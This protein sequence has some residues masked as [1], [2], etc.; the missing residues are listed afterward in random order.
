VLGHIGYAVVPWKRGRGYGKRA[1]ALLLAE[2]GGIGLP[3][4]DLT[5]D[6]ENLAS[7]AVILA[8]GGLLVERFRKPPAYGGQEALR[9]RIELRS[10][11]PA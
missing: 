1:L 8:N 6:P 3:F 11:P 10:G 7:H 5:T 9:F 4:V 2:I